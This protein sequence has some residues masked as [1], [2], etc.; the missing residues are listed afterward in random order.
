MILSVENLGIQRLV[1]A[2][3]RGLRVR[4]LQEQCSLNEGADDSSECFE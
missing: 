4:R 2:A 1:A 3:E